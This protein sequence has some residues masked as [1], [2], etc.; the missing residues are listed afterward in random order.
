M[1]KIFTKSLLIL[2]SLLILTQVSFSQVW[3]DSE[4]DYDQDLN[5][6][7]VEI[8]NN[9]KYRSKDSNTNNEVSDLQSFLQE[10][11]FLST[12]PTGYFGK[13]TEDAVKKYQI[14]KG[15]T[16][17]GYVGKLTRE[18]IKLDTCRDY[19]LQQGIKVSLFPNSVKEDTVTLGQKLARLADFNFSGN[20]EILR[21]KGFLIILY[22]IMFTCTVV[23]IYW[24]AQY[25]PIQMVQ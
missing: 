14:S 17:T 8:K 19:A 11:D 15:L 12:E 22:F 4:G 13:A 1:K 3:S 7:C 2:S 6:S 20:G 10:E 21:E 25:K 16:G 9:L 5:S 24:R 23:Q 18:K